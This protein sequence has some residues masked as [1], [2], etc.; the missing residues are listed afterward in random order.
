[1]CFALVTSNFTPIYKAES[2]A[3]VRAACGDARPITTDL[4]LGMPVQDW[5]LALARVTDVALSRA[6]CVLSSLSAGLCNLRLH[7]YNRSWRGREARL[8]RPWA[9]ESEKGMRASQIG[10]A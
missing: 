3:T 6:R 7:V 9:V 4:Q 2:L 1:M 5:R 10:T 8:H